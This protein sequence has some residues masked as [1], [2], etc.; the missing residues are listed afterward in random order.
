MSRLK[1]EM[2]KYERKPGEFDG[3]VSRFTDGKE[4]W[5]ESWW[6]SPP[7]DIDHVG[8]EYLQNPHRHPNVRT[9]RHDSFVK[10]RFKEEM[11]R[12]TSE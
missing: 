10:Q 8:R 1:F 9:A 11:A 12:L 4:N 3:Y 2:W 5:T 7:D 6:S